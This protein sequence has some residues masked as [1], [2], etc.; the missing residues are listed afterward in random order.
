MKTKIFGEILFSPNDFSIQAETLVYYLLILICVARLYT[1]SQSSSVRNCLSRVQEQT[2]VFIQFKDFIY[3]SSL[4]HI[5]QMKAGPPLVGHLGT[6]Q[7]QL[8]VSK[9]RITPQSLKKGML[10]FFQFINSLLINYSSKK[11]KGVVTQAH[12]RE[13][14]VCSG[15]ARG[16]LRAVPLP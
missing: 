10:D 4:L 8:T 6:E 11:F 13:M 9:R 16:A 7:Y 3:L 12:S 1:L 5:S 14:G 2:K 15:E